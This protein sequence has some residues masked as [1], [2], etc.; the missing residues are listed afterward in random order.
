MLTIN[1]LRRFD[2]LAGFVLCT[3][4]RL[5]RRTR[6]PIDPEL[7]P[8]SPRFL[9]IKC[10]GIGSILL[11]SPTLQALKRRWPKARITF[12]TL[13][14]NAGV[15]GLIPSID[16]VLTVNLRTMSFL[17]ET[18]RLFRTVRA[19]HFDA[20][21]DFEFSSNFTALVAYWSGSP[22]IGFTSLKP[23]RDILYD[24][25]IVFDHSLHARD[26][27]ARVACF[28]RCGPAG[29]PQMRTTSL[30]SAGKRFPFLKEPF[31]VVNP[32][33]GELSLQ[34]RWPRERY[35]ALLR[36]LLSTTEVVFVLIGSR[37]NLDYMRPLLE[38]FRSEPRVVSLAGDIAL[39][40][41]AALL[42]Q[43]SLYIG[44]DSGPM[45]L[46]ATVGTPCIAF[47][48]PETPHL[49][50]PLPPERHQVFYTRR[51]CSPCLNVYRYKVAT[52]RDNRCLKE[53]EVGPVVS[54]CRRMLAAVPPRAT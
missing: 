24:S 2:A 7:L 14:E 51:H 28:L 50:G 34:R 38:T 22:S 25:G 45:H 19:A 4:A 40:E 21:I 44:N 16:E 39:G 31:V 43:A 42:M 26:S 36:E 5:F 47:F 1:F 53:I 18:L 52:C 46:A 30:E 6:K 35:E 37:D 12:L 29:E 3:L 23:E 8:A 32:N 49:Y 11:L 48:G 10:W 13:T 15:C 9:C 17:R 33:A 54:A 20:V 27:F 41:L